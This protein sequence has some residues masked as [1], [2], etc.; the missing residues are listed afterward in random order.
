M[1]GKSD[2]QS[3]SD[4]TTSGQMPSIFIP[5]RLLKAELDL[6][7]AM[8]VSS[9]LAATIRGGFGY[10]LRRI[11]CIQHGIDCCKC[12][13]KN[14]CIY[15]F[16]FETPPP[17]DATR[18]K[19]YRN[20]PRPFALRPHQ[21]G[22]KVMMDLLLIGKAVEMV[23]FFIYTLNELGTKG[24]GRQ[25]VQFTVAKVCPEEG[26]PVNNAN[27][28]EEGAPVYNADKPE[29]GAPV[30]NADK[31]GECL[32]VAPRILEIQ[33]GS[34]LYGSIA[35]TFKTPLVIRKNEAVLSSFESY[36]F[37]TTLLRRITNLNAFYGVDPACAVDPR[38]W[39]DAANSIVCETE[40]DPV[41]QQ[42]FSTRQ[43]KKIDYSGIMGTVKL[44]GDIGTLI[45]LIKAGEILGVGKN[46][47]FGYG[48]YRCVEGFDAQSAVHLQ[49]QCT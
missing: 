17:P 38:Q 8:P 7:T 14:N 39:L 25:K 19:K 49:E 15:P 46:T 34:P 28:P 26:A 30:Y 11:V 24:L 23:P 16:L 37:F 21:H 40:T 41:R 22:S 33:A 29:E 43:N 48:V 4:S 36:P 3:P 13:M 10:T 1:P 5:C 44:T 42:R 20:V 35:I 47:V 2:K 45:P 9:F 32:H 6:Q 27:K 12:M 18:L 31:P